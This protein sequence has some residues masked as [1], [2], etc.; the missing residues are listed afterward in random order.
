MQLRLLSIISFLFLTLFCQAANAPL[1]DSLILVISQKTEDSLFLENQIEALRTMVSNRVEFDD[2][3]FRKLTASAKSLETKKQEAELIKLELNYWINQSE[4]D[5]VVHLSPKFLQRIKTIAPDDEWYLNNALGNFYAQCHK[6]KKA[7]ELYLNSIKLLEK[8]G[9]DSLKSIPLGNLGIC[10]FNFDDYENALTYI[11][12]AYQYS[13]KLKNVES[14]NFNA[15]HDLLLMAAINEKKGNLAKATKFYRQAQIIVQGQNDSYL[16]I[17]AANDY[18]KFQIEQQQFQEAKTL[19]QS[20]LRYA[21]SQ[22]INKHS[23]HF[24][25][26]LLNDLRYHSALEKSLPVSIDS[27]LACSKTYDCQSEII[28]FAIQHYNNNKDYK[29]AFKFASMRNSHL[30]NSRSEL[31]EQVSALVE[32]KFK[33]EQLNSENIV[34]KEN[35]Q[36]TSRMLNIFLCLLLGFLLSTYLLYGSN[37]KANELNTRLKQS[38]DEVR[39]QNKELEQLTYITTHDLKEPANTINV[40]SKLIEKKH[41][42]E[43]PEDS[44]RLFKIIVNTSNNMLEMISRLHSYL[45]V[46]NEVNLSEVDLN[47][48]YNKVM[49]NLRHQIEDKEIF[50]HPQSFPKI[51]GYESELMQLFQN[52]MANA[53]KFRSPDR[54]LEIKFNY[55]QTNNYHVI[56]IKDNGIGMR[57][58]S[59][60]KVFDLFQTLNGNKKYQGNGIGL[61][62]ARKI[63]ELHDGKIWVNSKFGEG[64][65]FS[66]TLKKYDY[67]S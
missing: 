55:Q 51:I 25:K 19:L 48:V 40:F 63:V 60:H 14:K 56:Q 28:K 42:E 23:D 64:S 6:P 26:L 7:I 54:K 67:A 46:G 9:R 32:D 29:K 53:I 33:K 65:I 34:L 37:K 27:V 59:Q 4:L 22:K 50:I 39:K 16:K 15:T 30:E 45:I 36:S 35:V 52:L 38:N 44:K 57:Q 43:L 31:S 47:E 18:L 17:K 66:F 61:A 20:T 49:D 3:Y 5:S 41:Y 2:E 24:A 8:I 1:V 62:N 10:Y 21:N 11:N 13:I 12:K 58:S